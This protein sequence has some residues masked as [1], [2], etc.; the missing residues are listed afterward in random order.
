LLHY[1][2]G[3]V[4]IDYG[5]TVLSVFLLLDEGKAA[6]AHLLPAG[7]TD[8]FVLRS[9]MEMGCYLVV[10]KSASRPHKHFFDLPIQAQ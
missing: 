4:N 6:L 3:T 7:L 8:G 10:G 9:A 2:G 1:F 5:H